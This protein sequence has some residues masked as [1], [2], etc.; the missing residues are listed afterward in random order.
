MVLK[1]QIGD[2]KR[3]VKTTKTNSHREH[4]NRD[5]NS[6]QSAR[7]TSRKYEHPDDRSELRVNR[8]NNK[9]YFCCKESGGKCNE[10]WRM[11]KPSECKVIL[12]K[13]DQPANTV[14]DEYAGLKAQRYPIK[15]KR[16]R[17]ERA[18]VKKIEIQLD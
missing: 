1:V 5:D 12:Q 14:K 4:E 10:I 9:T 2:P 8:F 16:A 15:K 17:F 7:R 18:L 6:P 13:C 11:H 3:L